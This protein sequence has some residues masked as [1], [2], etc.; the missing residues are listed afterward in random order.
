MKRATAGAAAEA[1]L[2]SWHASW[3]QRAE[4]TMVHRANWPCPR[5]VQVRQV[6][7]FV[8]GD[9][10][11]SGA[12]NALEARSAGAIAPSAWAEGEMSPQD[13]EDVVWS[14]ELVP[15]GG[16]VSHQCPH[17]SKHRAAPHS[18]RTHRAP[19]ARTSLHR[20]GRPHHRAA[21]GCMG[22]SSGDEGKPLAEEGKAPRERRARAN[23]N[24]AVQWQMH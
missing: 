23:S 12:S 17:P 16:G 7:D 24:T 9:R 18:L 10:P 5:R 11:M 8:I 3:R 2:S 6:A 21:A 22:R 19:T 20:G 13:M 14:S 4:A 1:L 15:L